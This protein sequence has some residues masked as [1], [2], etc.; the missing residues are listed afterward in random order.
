MEI[1][2]TLSE[3]EKGS[4]CTDTVESRVDFLLPIKWKFDMLEMEIKAIKLS[5][6]L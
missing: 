4:T 6:F 1:E 3:K 5:S 2:V